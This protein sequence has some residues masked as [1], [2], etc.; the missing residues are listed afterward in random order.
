MSAF[1]V[2]FGLIACNFL[3]L[4]VSFLLCV[5]DMVCLIGFWVFIWLKV[6]VSFTLGKFIF[7]L[8]GNLFQLDDKKG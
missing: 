6:A 7:E 3:T 8:F 5:I 1:F 4:F 2:S